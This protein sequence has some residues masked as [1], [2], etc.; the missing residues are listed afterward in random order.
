MT[1]DASG[2]VVSVMVQEPRFTPHEVDVLLASRREDSK[3]RGEHGLPLSVATDP[4]NRGKFKV[5]PPLRD[6]AAEK[7]H[8]EKSAFKSKYADEYDRYS[9]LWRVE[10]DE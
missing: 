8:A 4:E 1:V 7:L 6:F 2:E 3:P 5:P 9:W 10:V